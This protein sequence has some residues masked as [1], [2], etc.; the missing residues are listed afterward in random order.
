MGPTDW[1]ATL[2]RLS[3]HGLD[4]SGVAETEHGYA[5]VVGSRGGSLWARFVEHLRARPE[6]LASEPHPLDR[7]VAD[8]IAALPYRPE[9]RWVMADD[10]SLP[11]VSLALAA[12]LGWQS[13]LMMLLHPTYGHWVSLRAVCFTTED[14]S[15]LCTGPL[16]SPSPCEG[17]PAPCMSA[18]PGAAIREEGFDLRACARIHAQETL[19]AAACRA[20]DACPVGA[21]RRYPDLAVRYHTDPSAG[22]ARLEDHLGQPRSGLGVSFDW[23]SIL[24]S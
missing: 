16:S 1:P 24:D 20:R 17:C 15:S 21:E 9:R 10:P 13:K 7:Y 4:L 11:I 22:R 14:L 18:C 2:E 8:R 3:A 12:G 23:A 6:I 5:V 19:C